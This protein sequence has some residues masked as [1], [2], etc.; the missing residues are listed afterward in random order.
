M[1]NSMPRKGL[2][3][4]AFGLR[5]PRVEPR[6][7]FLIARAPQIM[8]EVARQWPRQYRRE[9]CDSFAHVLESLQVRRGVARVKFAVGDDSEAFAQRVG[10]LHK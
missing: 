2:V 8:L 7:R 6:E 3:S 10:K 1:R 5:I 9:P 4:F